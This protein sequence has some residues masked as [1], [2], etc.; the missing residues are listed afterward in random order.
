MR[1]GLWVDLTNTKRFYDR[2]V[3]EER[4][5]QYF[6]LNC[7]GHGE[8]PSSEQTHSFIQIVDDFINE[9]PFDIIAVHCTH[10]FNRTGFLIVSYLVERLDFG[11]EAALAT[12]AK[13]RPPGIYKQD[14]INELFRRYESEEDTIQAPPLPSW[15]LE[16][17]DSDAGSNR[18]RKFNDAQSS[19]SQQAAAG[20]DMQ[21]LE[22]DDE[23]QEEGTEGAEIQNAEGKPR[24]KRRREMIIKDA[25]FMAG[26][27]GVSLVSDQ[28]R[29]GEIQQTVQDMCGWSKS[30]FPGAQPVSMDR[31][32]IRRLHEIPYRVS[33]KADGTR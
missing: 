33:W 3:V 14:Y 2:K 8:T 31:V 7:R 18:K 21:T 26:V 16:Y 28:P 15:S 5:A 17:D 6:K 29:L 13:A 4:G 22:D 19:T 32:N 20:N 9:H 1:L 11:V 12:F 24:K 25:T 23:D 30:G 27:P 10:G